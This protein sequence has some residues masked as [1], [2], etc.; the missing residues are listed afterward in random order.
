MVC[1]PECSSTKQITDLLIALIAVY[2]KLYY[3]N[4][5]FLFAVNAGKKI[6]KNILHLYIFCI[7]YTFKNLLKLFKIFIKIYRDI[8]YYFLCKISNIYSLS[9]ENLSGD[10]SLKNCENKDVLR[11]HVKLYQKYKM[12]EK[13]ILY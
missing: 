12:F 9:T 3:L 2:L 5:P 8:Y 10:L 6:I 1:F 11:K 13:L 4:I 7:Y